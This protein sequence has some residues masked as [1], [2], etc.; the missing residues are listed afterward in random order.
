MRIKINFKH[1]F[2]AWLASLVAAAGAAG[3]FIALAGPETTSLDPIITWWSVSLAAFLAMLVAWHRLVNRAPR[4]A[5]WRGALAGLLT[6]LVA[7]PLS[8]YLQFAYSLLAEGPGSLSWND[9]LLAVLAY[10]WLFGLLGWLI[11]GWITTPLGILMGALLG[12]LQNRLS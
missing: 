5:A 8:F 12:Y 4:P 1:Q 10:P 3:V 2:W 11:A 6:S 9:I 7:Y